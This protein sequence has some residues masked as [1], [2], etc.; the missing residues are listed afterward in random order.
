M[1]EK[2]KWDLLTE[3]VEW[4]VQEREKT[5]LGSLIDL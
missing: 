4:L 5:S 2:F 1:V 3:A